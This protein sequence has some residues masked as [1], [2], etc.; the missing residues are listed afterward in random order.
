MNFKI[1]EHLPVEVLP[2][3]CLS[4]I[5]EFTTEASNKGK[6]PGNKNKRRYYD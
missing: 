6:M 2:F 4:C 3:F 5:L 1:D